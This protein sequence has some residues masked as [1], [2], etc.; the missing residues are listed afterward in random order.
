[1]RLKMLVTAAFALLLAAGTALGQSLEGYLD[2]YVTKVRPEKRA[3]FDAIVKKMVEVNRKNKGDTW[4]AVETAYG[5]HN[6]VYFISA[7][8][9]YAGIEQGMGAFEGALGKAF[10]RAGVAKLFQDFNNTMV[11]SRGEIRRR[12]VELSS[13]LPEPAAFSRWVG[14]MRW[15]RSVVVRVRPGRLGD[16]QAQLQAN[17]AAREKDRSLPPLVVYQAVEGQQGTVFY[18]NSLR[19]SLGG[20]D[21]SGSPGLPQLLGDDGYRKYV[22][23][24]R[25]SVLSTE[26]LI[27]RFNPELSNP[28]ED[29][30]AASPDFWR[31]KPPPAA[32]KPAAAAEGAKTT[33]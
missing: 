5:E 21:P 23:V 33:P 32:K 11:S 25:E 19:S 7:R 8:E 18:L 16:Y 17:K 4:V 30:A 22:Q 1:M 20:F 3:E 14:E 28:P 24:T 2:L 10:G 6:T 15:L 27:H 26:T 9:Q 12:R 31:P 13:N 29:V